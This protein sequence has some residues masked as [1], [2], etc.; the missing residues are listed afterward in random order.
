MGSDAPLPLE[1]AR[2]VDLANFQ[3]DAVR[4]GLDMIR[5]YGGCY[6]ADVVGLGKTHIGA[7]LLRQLRQSYPHD[8]P[9]LI[10]CPAGMTDTWERFNELYGLGAE[11]LSQ[12]RI[13]PPPGLIPNPPKR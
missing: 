9:P 8:G 10:I 5:N 4:R 12:A 6:I 3:L 13:A 2:Q 7:E 11:V 1:P